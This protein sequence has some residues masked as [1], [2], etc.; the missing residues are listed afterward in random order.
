MREDMDRRTIRDVFEAPGRETSAPQ[1]QSAEM[2]SAP[3]TLG[4][5]FKRLS[6]ELQPEAQHTVPEPIIAEPS[7]SPEPIVEAPAVPVRRSR[8]MAAKTRVRSSGLSFRG[9]DVVRGIIL[10]EI[11]GPPVSMREASRGGV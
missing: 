5:I 9:P 1:P 8:K 10:S 6:G 2:P 7:Y 3:P 4:D 11:L